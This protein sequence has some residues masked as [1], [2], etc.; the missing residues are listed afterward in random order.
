M[1][2]SIYDSLLPTPLR[3]FIEL[4]AD[5]RRTLI[6]ISTIVA[7]VDRAEEGSL[8]ITR[9]HVVGL[10]GQS[11]MAYVKRSYNEIIALLKQAQ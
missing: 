2:K 1:A 3:G 7:V 10:T 8:I 9:E 4:I 11:G 6:A 5:E